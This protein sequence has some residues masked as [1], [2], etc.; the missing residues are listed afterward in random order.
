[1]KRMSSRNTRELSVGE[2]ERLAME[3]TE[4]LFNL[5]IRNAAGAL[6]SSA[7]IAVLRRDIAQIKTIQSEKQRGLR[8]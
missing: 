5:K 3:K 4:N 1:M 7:D 6:S 8:S 2:L